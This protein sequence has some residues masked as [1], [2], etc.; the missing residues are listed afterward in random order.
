MFISF[1]ID[2][3]W[4]LIRYGWALWPKAVVEGASQ[5]Q[6][7]TLHWFRRRWTSLHA[8]RGHSIKRI[9][10]PR[11]VHK[12]AWKRKK[13]FIVSLIGCKLPHSVG[14]NF[15]WHK[16]AYMH[17]HY[18]WLKN[19]AK[20]FCALKKRLLSFFAIATKDNDIER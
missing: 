15:G 10:I 4:P 3:S 7:S 18:L 17:H 14:K 11:W 20:K 13:W 19:E 5:H 9:P 12:N 1:A 16:S 8:H 6:L 2:E